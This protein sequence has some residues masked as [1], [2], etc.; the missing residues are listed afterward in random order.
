[1]AERLWTWDLD[2]AFMI[3]PELVAGF[4]TG[5]KQYNSELHQQKWA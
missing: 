5:G 1:M 3:A 4:V 2:V